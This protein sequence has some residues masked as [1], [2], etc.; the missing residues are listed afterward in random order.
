M[1]VTALT[2]QLLTLTKFS[3]EIVKFVVSCL[4]DLRVTHLGVIVLRSFPFN[5]KKLL[6]LPRKSEVQF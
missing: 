3:P 1:A 6:N 2:S 4:K 5:L